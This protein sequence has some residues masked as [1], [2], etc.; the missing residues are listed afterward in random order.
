MHKCYCS[1]LY[2]STNDRLWRSWIMGVAI[3]VGMAC[4][5][6][7]WQLIQARVSTCLQRGL[8]TG[9]CGLQRPSLWINWR[10]VNLASLVYHQWPMTYICMQPIRSLLSFPCTVGEE[11][12][13]VHQACFSKRRICYKWRQCRALL[14]PASSPLK[15]TVNA[16][17]HLRRVSPALQRP[18]LSTP[19]LPSPWVFLSTSTLYTEYDELC[20]PQTWK[21]IFL[22]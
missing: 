21:S 12:G 13:I 7:P 1:W 4:D 11:L 9:D 3:T 15:T 16:I 2:N 10:E 5:K 6:P 17:P 22:D 20:E 19:Q 18:P 14:H 8:G